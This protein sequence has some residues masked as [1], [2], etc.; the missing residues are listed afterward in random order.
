MEA[1][2]D[3]VDHDEALLC[4]RDEEEDATQPHRAFTQEVHGNWRTLGQSCPEDRGA[5]LVGD[6]QL[7][8]PGLQDS[9]AFLQDARLPVALQPAELLRR[10]LVGE[11]GCGRQEQ[12]RKQGGRRRPGSPKASFADDH[13]GL[14]SPGMHVRESLDQANGWG[15]RFVR[16]RDADQVAVIQADETRI[17]HFLRKG[18]KAGGPEWWKDIPL[19]HRVLS[20]GQVDPIFCEDRHMVTERRLL[21]TMTNEPF[22]PVRLYYAI[23]DRSF[24]T[25]KLR[26]L[27][28]A[29]EVPHERA[30]QWLFDAEAASLRFAAGGYE[31]VPEDRRPIVLGRIRFPKPGGMT[32]Q[33]NSIER[34]IAG[35][36]FFA[37]RLGPEVV[38]LRVRVVNRCFAADEGALDKL[39]ATLD[40]DV[41]VIDPREAEAALGREFEGVRSQRDAERAAEEFLERST[42]S[43]DDVPMVEDLPLHPEEETP[44]FQ[45]LAT[46]L[47]FRFVRAFEHWRGNTHLTLAAIIRRTIEAHAQA[48]PGQRA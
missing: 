34:A 23:P 38:A 12:K 32:L 1:V 29:V 18:Q 30:W 20:R 28:C 31:D 8:Q 10:V 7:R 40:Q 19:G 2:L 26:G 36:R 39:V 24:V 22:Q 3:F 42:R 43:E 17:P 47:Q 45:D 21:V 35:A 13:L 41:T 6:E 25:K 14:E 4:R 11:A 9:E 16:R 5:G 15:A 27:G 44:D 48:Q 37:P 46:T 33:T